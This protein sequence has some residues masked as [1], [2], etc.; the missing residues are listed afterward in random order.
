MC[1]LEI[2]DDYLKKKWQV[3]HTFNWLIQVLGVGGLYKDYILIFEIEN[4]YSIIKNSK[5]NRSTV[6]YNISMHGRPKIKTKT[7]LL[8]YLLKNVR[9]I[10]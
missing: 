1:G 9:I 4:G 6:L 3:N 5:E 7:F 8:N 10:L 2:I